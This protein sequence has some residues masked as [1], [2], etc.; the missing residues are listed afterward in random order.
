VRSSY[1]A[2][3]VAFQPLAIGIRAA[4]RTD[5]HGNDSQAHVSHSMTGRGS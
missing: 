2:L 1:V 5:D 4:G 3:V